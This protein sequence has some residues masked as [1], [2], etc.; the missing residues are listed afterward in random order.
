MVCYLQQNADAG[1]DAGKAFL[2]NPEVTEY[3][4]QLC[5]E[6][7]EKYGRMDIPEGSSYVTNEL[8]KKYQSRITVHDIIDKHLEL[9]SYWKIWMKLI[10]DEE[11]LVALD[12]VN[13]K[14]TTADNSWW[15]RKLEVSF[16]FCSCCYIKL[17]EKI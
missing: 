11:K 15:E 9:L 13:G 1:E 17:L 4:C 14:I 16:H 12:W 8:N 3:Y 10:K 6:R 2:S 7:V 5:V